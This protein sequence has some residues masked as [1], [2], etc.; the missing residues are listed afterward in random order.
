MGYEDLPR[1]NGSTLFC[2]RRSLDLLTA[3]FAPDSERSANIPKGPSRAIIRTF[4]EIALHG[5]SLAFICIRHLF[6][7][8]GS[9][10][11]SNA[12]IGTAVRFAVK[13]RTL[14]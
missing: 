1:P 12:I 4:T 13:F 9:K 7:G 3:G 14:C 6:R 2:K 11:S 8:G 5:M 10:L